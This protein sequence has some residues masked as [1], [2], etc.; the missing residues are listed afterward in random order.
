MAIAAIGTALPPRRFTQADVLSWGFDNVQLSEP[1][2]ALYARMLGDDSIEARHLA[3]DDLREILETDH[4]RILS[5][6]ERWA[7]TLSSAA[8]NQALQRA[9]VAAEQIEY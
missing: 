9:G 5:R 6:F 8:L 3:V 4:E 1:T 7:A 2:R